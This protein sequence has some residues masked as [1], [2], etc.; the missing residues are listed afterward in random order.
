VAYN[1]PSKTHAASLP[2]RAICA[3]D[4]DNDPGRPMN[5]NIKDTVP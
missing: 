1:K 5:L 2:G 4:K 3:V